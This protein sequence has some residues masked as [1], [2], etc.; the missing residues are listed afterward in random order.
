M[1][2]PVRARARRTVFVVACFVLALAPLL[3]TSVPARAAPVPVPGPVP[4]PTS[5][6]EYLWSTPVVSAAAPYCHPAD[7]T[8]CNLGNDLIRRIAAVPPGGAID[9]I[10]YSTTRDD[11]SAALVAA[12]ARG[13]TVRML[14]SHP[15]PDG[16]KSGD[17]ADKVQ[18]LVDG[19]RG[20]HQ[21][22]MVGWG[23]LSRSGKS[24][25]EHRKIVLIDPDPA[26]DGDEQTISD[27]GNWT[28]SLDTAYNDRTVV[29]DRCLY[30]QAR[31]HL[32]VLWKDRTAKKIGPMSTCDGRRQLWMMPEVK[33]DPV[34]D[35]AERATCGPG[36]RVTFANF[37]LAPSKAEL[38]D[39]LIRFRKAGAYVQVAANDGLTGHYST[40]QKRRMVAAGIKVY[41]VSVLLD[42]VSGRKV[43]D[44]EKSL[45][46]TGCGPA[47]S[48]Q[49]ST[50]QNTTAY[51]RNGNAILTS[52]V[53]A[54]A[55]AMQT[56]FAAMIAGAHRLTLAD[57]P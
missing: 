13:V 33:T 42:P 11:L 44:H 53:W 39:Q 15:K 3:G 12:A 26:I 17:V 6:S 23:S 49:G 55:A 45:S 21:P 40:T 28:Y 56:G 34:L 27:S 22:V 20:L 35:W 52:S 18:A 25:L 37:Y 2:H 19:L 5:T 14:T 8:P 1:P 16:E 43:Y 57:L 29:T 10:M 4:P 9:L 50:T 7:L 24:G 48:A 51:T 54:D 41:D 38:V 47:F 30:D 46:A 32:D 36:S 31:A